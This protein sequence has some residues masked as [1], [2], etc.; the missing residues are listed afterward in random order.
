MTTG[1]KIVAAA[2]EYLGVPF[3][4]QGRSRRGLDCIGL[5]IMVAHEL[6]LAPPD[7]D[8]TAYRTQP[9]PGAMA[10]ALNRYCTRTPAAGVAPGHI[11][12]LAEGVGGSYA[13]YPSHAGIIGTDSSG[14]LTL[15]HSYVTA[16]Q[17]VEVPYTGMWVDKTVGI[18]AFRGVTM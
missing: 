14:A 11:V 4:H 3:R 17:V 7:A 15:I 13:A 10:A 6:G 12:L 5:I 8:F 1:A 18:W 16:R 2:R 9:Q